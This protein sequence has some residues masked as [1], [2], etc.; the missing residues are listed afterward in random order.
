MNL[1]NI[2]KYYISSLH[3]VKEETAIDIIQKHLTN[4]DYVLVKNKTHQCSNDK[5]NT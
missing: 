5:E 3:L 4:T 2:E 1:S